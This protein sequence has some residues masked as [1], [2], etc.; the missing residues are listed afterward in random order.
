M[1]DSCSESDED[2]LLF[3]ITD[4]DSAPDSSRSD[5]RATSGNEADEESTASRPKAAMPLRE[6]RIKRAYEMAKPISISMK[7]LVTNHAQS[8]SSTRMRWLSAIHKAKKAQDPWAGFHI[9]CYETEVC[10][11]HQYN[12]L[13]KTWTSDEVLVKMETK[14][15]TNGAMRQCYRLK[16][17]MTFCAQDWRHAPNYVAKS[18][19]EQVERQVYFQDVRLQMDAKLWGQEYNRHNPPKKVDIFQM[20]VLEFKNRA[21]SPLY[22]LEHFIEGNYIKYNSNSGF[23]EESYRLTPQAFSHFTFE[24]SG[25]KLIVVDVQGVGD[26]YTDPQIHTSEGTD[27]GDGN[28]GP[29]GMALFFHSHVCNTICQSLELAP[30]D[31][32][33]SELTVQRTLCDRQQCAVTRVRGSEE[34][35]LSPSPREMVDLTALL[36]RHRSHNSLSSVDD[37]D[38][39]PMTPTSEDEPMFTDT[40]SPGYRPRRRC[41][42]ET[43]TESEG[44]ITEGDHAKNDCDEE[45]RRLFSEAL[46][47]AHRPSCVNMELDFRRLS[48]LI[49]GES[50]LGQIHH[51]MAK[52]HEMGRFS[53][54]EGDVDWEAALFHEEH[55][56]QLGV[57][58]ATITLARLYLGLPRDV[59]VSCSVQPSTENTD[60]GVDYMLQAAEAGDRSAMIYL[61][62]AFDT[63]HNLGSRRSRSWEDAL[64]WYDEA[65]HQMKQDDGGEFD[66]TMEDP[67]Y[68][69]VA[70]QAEMYLEGGYGLQKDPYNAGDLFTK[71]AEAATEAMKGRLANK[72]FMQAEEAWALLEDEEAAE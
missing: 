28:L 17:H 8:P 25:H 50:V 35:C 29:K 6:R 39:M 5:S 2:I 52:Y 31:M 64:H 44:S 37:D 66:S 14:P 24:R 59:L 68:L 61:A 36:A 51:A 53:V 45:E 49:I 41:I 70:R 22:H 13:K 56:A 11:R 48:N 3:P 19:M 33:P 16:K 65:V 72:L 57:V 18:Y 30:F 34:L 12:A 62:R 46:K 67:L 1:S 4:L 58:E 27:Y 60:V 38:P 20:Y 54:E 7:P 32:A 55:A 42:S 26:L 21:G 63:G 40:D 71:A 23:V 47:K 43:T 15:F 10:T 9:D 69:L